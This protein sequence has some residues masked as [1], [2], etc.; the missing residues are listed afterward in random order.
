MQLF[1]ERKFDLIIT[2]ILMPEK[3]GFETIIDMRRDNPEL[4]IVAISGG[5]FSSPQ[6]YLTA[7]KGIGANYTLQKPFGMNELVNAVSNLLEND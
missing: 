6:N 7:A 3:D 4:K 5:F 1:K 2:D